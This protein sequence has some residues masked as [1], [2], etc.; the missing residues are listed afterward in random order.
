MKGQFIR[1]VVL[2]GTGRVL[3]SS[4]QIQS[5]ES[6]GELLLQSSAHKFGMEKV[7]VH[8]VLTVTRDD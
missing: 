1:G 6:E 3:H 2:E 7:A 5:F 4:A 8:S